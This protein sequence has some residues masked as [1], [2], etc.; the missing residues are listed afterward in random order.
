MARLNDF[1]LFWRLRLLPLLCNQMRSPRAHGLLPQD[2][3]R[4]M[5]IPRCLN[6][7]SFFVLECQGQALF[8]FQLRFVEMVLSEAAILTS[9]TGLTLIGRDFH[10]V[11]TSW[12]WRVDPALGHTWSTAACEVICWGACRFV[13]CN[14]IDPQGSWKTVP[15][16][17]CQDGYN[18]FGNFSF[19]TVTTISTIRSYVCI[20]ESK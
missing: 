3:S 5:C 16:I 20:N 1:P 13:T 10:E 14:F 18:L 4:T 2:A 17:L 11:R 8:L 15:C 7:K 12:P 9:G 19:E 6:E